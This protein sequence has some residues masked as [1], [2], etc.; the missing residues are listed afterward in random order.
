VRQIIDEKTSKMV[1]FKTDAIMLGGVACQ[2]RYSKCRRFCPRAILPYWREIWLERAATA[3][4]TPED[5]RKHLTDTNGKRA[6]GSLWPT[7]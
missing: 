3:L 1:R 7:G 5:G 2:A 4:P 6:P